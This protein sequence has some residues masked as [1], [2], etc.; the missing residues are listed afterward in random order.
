MVALPCQAHSNDSTR[1]ESHQVHC[2]AEAVFHEARGE[3]IE[4]QAAVARVVMNRTRYPKTFGKSIC[5]VVY[6]KGQFSWAPSEKLDW[7]RHQHDPLFMTITARSFFW[8]IEDYSNIRYTKK[9]VWE[10]TYFS[11]TRPLAHNLKLSVVIGHHHFFN[12]PKL[13]AI[14][15]G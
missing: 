12:N 2:L 1:T 7:T 11:N 10:A 4:G 14:K 3:S 13:L 15:Q 8:M 5:E 9:G 6:Q